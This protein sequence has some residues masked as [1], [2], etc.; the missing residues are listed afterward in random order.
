M[1]V[2]SH[3]RFGVLATVAVLGLG[4]GT[5]C[6]L[7]IELDASDAVR[8]SGRI[9]EQ[10][11]EVARFDQIEARTALRVTIEPGDATTLVVKGDDN[12]V[13]RVETTVSDRRLRI[14]L[15]PDSSI[16]PTEPLE[17][18]VTVPRLTSV[19]ALG[20]TE[21]RVGPIA[22]E[23]LTAR[24]T[25]ASRVTLEGLTAQELT[26][27]AEG[28]SR[29]RADGHVGPVRLS[30][31]GASNASLGALMARSVT[32]D[33]A[34]AS[35]A[36]VTASGPVRGAVSGASKLTVVGQPESVD[37]RT[38]GAGSVA[39]RPEATLSAEQE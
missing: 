2:A 7:H 6:G 5:G 9:I 18:V 39:R 26:L 21:V 1:A 23:A 10:R 16:Q 35:A 14:Q 19:E 37:V 28:A 27:S 17:A 12:L 31:S 15:R 30:V 36:E 20:A 13:H 4:L 24:A 22:C 33:V 3:C 29:L 34:G 32:L 11:R 25:G 38:S 8:G